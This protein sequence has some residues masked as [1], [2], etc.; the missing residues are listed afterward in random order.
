LSSINDWAFTGLLSDY[1][2]NRKSLKHGAA[3]WRR[4]SVGPI[5]REISIT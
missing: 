1:S 2:I 3:E 4:R 5:L